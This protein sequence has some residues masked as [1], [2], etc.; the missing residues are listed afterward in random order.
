MT[1]PTKA[2][3]LAAAEQRQREYDEQVQNEYPQR[4][5]NVLNAAQTEG[6]EVA[7]NGSTMSFLVWDYNNSAFKT[8]LTLAY[9]SESNDSLDS[10]SFEVRL[11]FEKRKEQERLA[12]VKANA[13]SKLSDEERRVLGY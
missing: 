1:K 13:L 3:K 8:P 10:L 2:E 9:S 12:N 6:Y 4:L 7:V 5:M 11:K